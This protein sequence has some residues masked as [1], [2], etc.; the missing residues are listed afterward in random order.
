MVH[1]KRT[2]GLRVGRRWDKRLSSSECALGGGWLVVDRS[3]LQVC[4]R[5]RPL[6]CLILRRISPYSCKVLIFRL[7][8]IN[9]YHV[10]ELMVFAIIV[11]ILVECGVVSGIVGGGGVF[12]LAFAC[13]LLGALSE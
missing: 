7:R 6:A 13:A 3:G 1:E 10:H 2:A 4:L 8:K 5:P 9:I 11:I 12:A